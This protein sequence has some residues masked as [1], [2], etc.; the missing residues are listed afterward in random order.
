MQSSIIAS[1]DCIKAFSETDITEVLRRLKCLDWFFI[2][3]Q[4]RS[5]ARQMDCFQTNSEILGRNVPL[6]TDKIAH[7][8]NK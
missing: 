3:T 6:Q 4:I 1:Y 8:L 2:E 7:L 5:F